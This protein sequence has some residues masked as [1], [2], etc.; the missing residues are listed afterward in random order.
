MLDAPWRR[1]DMPA[2][3]RKGAPAPA[4]MNPIIRPAGPAD[5][6]DI[7][8]VQQAAWAETYDGILPETVIQRVGA[9][10]GIGHWK[11]VLSQVDRAAITLVIEDDDAGPIGF[12]VC[13]PQ[14]GEVDGFD[15][16]IYALYL[17]APAQRQGLGTR[18]M[19]AMARLLR[20]RGFSS[21]L[22]WALAANA[23]ARHFYQALGGTPIGP[24][25]ARLFGEDMAEAGYGWDDMATLASLGLE[26]EGDRR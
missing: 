10:W 13:G 9:L 18:M 14:R 23:G 8:A 20:A 22:V 1:A 6:E 5:A 7:A 4:A 16:E 3:M 15:A 17:L 11:R 19:G 25:L 26:Q 12:A 24:R 2:S 21:L